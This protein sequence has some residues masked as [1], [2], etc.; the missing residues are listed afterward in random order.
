MTKET[1]GKVINT[2]R[3]LYFYDH[4]IAKNKIVGISSLWN[5]CPD[6]LTQIFFYYIYTQNSQIE[7]QESFSSLEDKVKKENRYKEFIEAYKQVKEAIVEIIE[8]S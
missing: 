8:Q 3:A 7:I 1:K 2:E 5:K 4:V 6:Q